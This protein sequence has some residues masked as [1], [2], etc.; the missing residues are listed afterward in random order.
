[1]GR[2]A[3]LLYCYLILA[4]GIIILILANTIMTYIKHSWSNRVRG[5]VFYFCET[6]RSR[7]HSVF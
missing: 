6:S 1:M 4:L 5:G 3:N 2:I 7:E